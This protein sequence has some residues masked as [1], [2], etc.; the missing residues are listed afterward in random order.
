MTLVEVYEESRLYSFLRLAVVGKIMDL[1][2]KLL[3]PPNECVCRTSFI[4]V[5]LESKISGLVA[6]K[7]VVFSTEFASVTTRS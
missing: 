2:L 1:G 3:G 5:S 7:Q 4:L 6:G